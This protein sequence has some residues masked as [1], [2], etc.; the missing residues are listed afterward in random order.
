MKTFILSYIYFVKQHALVRY[1]Y[2]SAD[3]YHYCLD[4]YK[5]FVDTIS[6]TLRKIDGL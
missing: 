5:Y 6:F 4:S 2:V 3:S 1:Y